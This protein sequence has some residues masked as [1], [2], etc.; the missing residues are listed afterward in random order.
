MATLLTQEKDVVG[1]LDK[2]LKMAMED[3]K[4]AKEEAKKAYAE[5]ES[6]LKTL[7]Q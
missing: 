4:T 5:E 7:E 6:A 2:A 3:A 1:R